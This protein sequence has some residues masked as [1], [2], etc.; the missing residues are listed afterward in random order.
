[1]KKIYTILFHVPANSEEEALNIIRTNAPFVYN[2]GSVG[3][4]EP[5]ASDDCERWLDPKYQY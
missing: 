4:N 3:E 1:M 5:S 2:D